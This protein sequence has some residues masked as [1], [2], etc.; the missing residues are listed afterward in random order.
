MVDQTLRKKIQ[1]AKD[2]D[3]P[4]GK[5]ITQGEAEKMRDAVWNALK[6]E[7]GGWGGLFNTLKRIGIGDEVAAAAKVDTMIEAA[8]NTQKMRKAATD[9]R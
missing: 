5:A 7:Y 3:S 1:E 8:V 2:P 9:P 4:G 6:S